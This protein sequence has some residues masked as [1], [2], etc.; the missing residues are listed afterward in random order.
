[1]TKIMFDPICIFLTIDFSENLYEY[2]FVWN[3][4]LN[5]KIMKKIAL[6]LNK[7]TIIAFFFIFE[8]C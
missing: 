3:Q 7:F 4:F 8:K 1:M 2:F 5:I 6:I